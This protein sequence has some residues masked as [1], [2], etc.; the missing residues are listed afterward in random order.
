MECLFF[1]VM[2]MLSAGVK[3]KATIKL[4]EA[5]ITKSDRWVVSESKNCS[6]PDNRIEQT[7]HKQ[8]VYSLLMGPFL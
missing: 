4:T 7:V 1:H 5:E 6:N 2:L 3:C 8:F